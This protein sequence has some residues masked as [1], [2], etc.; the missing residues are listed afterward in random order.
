MKKIWKI[1]CVLATLT[2]VGC[3]SELNKPILSSEDIAE[4]KSLPAGKKFKELTVEEQAKCRTLITKAFE[5]AQSD[6]FISAFCAERP[7]PASCREQMKFQT[8]T[9]KT[10]LS[11]ES[12][13]NQKVGDYAPRVVIGAL[14]FTKRLVAA[15][16]ELKKQDFAGGLRKLSELKN[17]VAKEFGA[18][19]DNFLLEMDQFLEKMERES[20]NSGF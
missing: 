15:I 10:Q 2:A 16:P 9:T 13:F 11:N 7:N 4:L 5:D 12:Q 18:G 17:E 8:E 14:A 1:L 3:A 20:G 19:S 6:E